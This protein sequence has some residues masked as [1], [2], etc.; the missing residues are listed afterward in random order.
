MSGS[1]CLTVKGVLRLN[2]YMLDSQIPLTLWFLIKAFGMWGFLPKCL[3][4]FEIAFW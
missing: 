2:L 3:S 4:S 1:R